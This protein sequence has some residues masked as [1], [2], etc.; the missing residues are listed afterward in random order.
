MM[1]HNIIDLYAQLL[2][3]HKQRMGICHVVKNILRKPVL[4][5][6]YESDIG[7]V[8]DMSEIAT[9]NKVYCCDTFMIKN[10]KFFF[11]C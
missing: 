4:S 8:R 2:F 11:R 9:E 5:G 1:T 3:A 10:P 6:L 7:K